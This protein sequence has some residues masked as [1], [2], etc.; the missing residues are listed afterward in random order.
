MWKKFVKT[1]ITEMVPWE[2]DFDM[3]NVSVAAINKE[4]G[5]PRAGDMIA[6][7]PENHADKWLVAEEFFKKNYKQA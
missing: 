6:R 4:T 3:E 5:S 7:D 2:P 1:Q